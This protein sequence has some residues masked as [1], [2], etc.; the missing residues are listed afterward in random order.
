MKKKKIITVIA[1]LF[2]AFLAF[3]P[4]KASAE[5]KQTAKA[6]RWYYL[7]ESRHKVKSKWVGD[8]YLDKNGYLVR[9][10]W[11]VGKNGTK[12]FVGEDGKWIPNFKKGW[13]M[14]GRK[15]YFYTSAGRKKTGFFTYKNNKYYCNENGIMLTG[16]RKINN[17]R[18]YFKSSG[19][20]LYGFRTIKG[21]RYYFAKDKK[22]YA[23]AGLSTIKGKLYYFNSISKMQKGWLTVNNNTYY[24]G[25]DGAAY[26]GWQVVSG[27]QYY[28]GTNGVMVKGLMN[29]EGK[30]YYFND[31]GIMLKNTTVTVNG[32]DYTV[33]SSGVC[34]DKV[35]EPAGPSGTV[36]TEML[37]FTKYESGPEAYAQ[38]GGDNGN[39][40][41]KYQF[42]YRYSLLPLIK[43]CY[44][45]D[46]V[47]FA[48][49]APFA[50]YAVTDKNKAKLKGNK[51]LYR[52]WNTIYLRDPKTFANYQDAFAKQ[53]YYD[54]AERLLNNMGVNIK[55]RR[56]VIK[57]AVFSYAIQHGSYT[58]A[59]AVKAAGIGNGTSDKNFINKLY[60]Y[61][62]SRFPLYRN[63]YT[64]EKME[65]LSYIR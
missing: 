36:S 58:A 41:G 43:Y 23:L 5:W 11:I 46:P 26:M 21:N 35:D 40:C 4:I 55:F 52:A 10:K 12:Y 19:E 56:D 25:S 49:F 44:E 50:S 6:K 48:E 54:E 34:S 42:D 61:R 39:A 29:I 27:N 17:K 15:W 24:F 37:F 51:K 33:G 16:L 13:H 1:L 20:M 2:F 57:G 45:G 18:Y 65:A 62:I 14:I 63:R 28:F 60:N 47:T 3:Q 8:Y 32:K 38:T 7:D 64:S 53:E 59:L 31:N 22:G 9:N 30:Q